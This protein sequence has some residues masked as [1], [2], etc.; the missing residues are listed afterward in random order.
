[1][2]HVKH[3][4]KYD[5]IV[6][7]AGHA[8]LEAATMASRLGAK[9][10]IV[11]FNKNDVGTLSCNPAMGGLGK[12][13]LI[14]EIDAMG[15][16]IGKASDLSG[17]QFR[18]LNKTRG[19]AVQGPRAQIDREKYKI[20]TLK[21][22][23]KENV[24]ILYDE[25]EDI[26]LD[27]K[28]CTK[29]IAGLRLKNTGNLICKSIVITTGTFLK[30]V[31]HQ[32]NKNWPAGRMGSKPSV[33]LAEFFKENSF[34]LLRLKT[35][36]PPRLKSDSINYDV[37]ERQEGDKVPKPFSFMTKKISN[38]QINC[39]ITYTNS[40]T[41]N[42][43]RKNLDQ[44]PIFNGNIQSRGPRYCPSLEDKIHRF[45]NKERHQIF[46]EPE[47][48]TSSTV[49]PNGISTSLP[50]EVQEKLLKTIK[51]L[52]N[53]KI[54]QFG[55]TIE[56]DCLDSSEIQ[57]NYETKKISGLFLAGQING[58]TGYEEAAAQGLL[59]GI[60]AAKKVH[61]EK[62]VIIERSQAYLGVLTSD[63]TR[64]G[65]VE[66]YR[67]FT[68]RA[69]YRLL[70]RSD[71]A[72]ERLT[73]LAIK[74]GTAEPLRKKV[75]E[76][77]KNLM[78]NA[79]VKLNKLK[80]SPQHYSNFNIKINQDGRKRSAFEILGYKDVNW[81]KLKKIW[82][83]LKTL[84]INREI[85]NQIKINSFYKRYSERQLN[86]I[87]DLEKDRLLKIKSS[88][89][90]NKCSGLSNEV[91]EILTTNKPHNIQEAR[92]LPGMT[93]AAASIL[94]RFVKNK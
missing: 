71:N 87:N 27:R 68:S 60:N 32:G 63:L 3:S 69:E 13:H 44:S 42:I 66:P 20:N 2:F 31:I 89:D 84:G 8:G 34:T 73:D 78:N 79:Y 77:K 52:K 26:L 59:A 28:N 39:H 72:D 88:V 51:G 38:K 14:R 58:T 30:G 33:R 11:T 4:D 90:Y 47:S 55:Y 43:V 53:V 46:L 18:V 61:G 7:G 93:P 80:A 45:P 22:L 17:I 16:L 37:C 76:T 81:S 82:P 19:E 54:E 74:I 23:K 15:G 49:Y 91:K 70:L 25:V 83:E 75:W 48:L 86:E 6:V 9:T 29:K 62:P 67:M 40:K 21:L 92:Q 85:E 24:K 65:L 12:G 64:G 1:M 10:A 41:H 56:Y 36:T 35:G 94:L 57:K 50:T 5:V